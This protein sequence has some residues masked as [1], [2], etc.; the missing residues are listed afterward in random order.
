[1]VKNAGGSK[2]KGLARK[3]IN[4]SNQPTKLRI[5][6]EEGEQVACVTKMLGNGMCEIYTNNEIRLIGHIRGSFRGRQKRHNTITNSS[7]DFLISSN[8]FELGGYSEVVNTEINMVM[9]DAAAPI[10]NAQ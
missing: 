8:S 1:M 6:N 5:P 2:T 4:K 3:H 10:P 7:F 9:I